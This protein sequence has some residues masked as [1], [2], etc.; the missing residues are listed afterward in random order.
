MTVSKSFPR[1]MRRA[2]FIG[3]RERAA[4]SFN[5]ANTTEF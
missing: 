3:I 4:F 2:R 1:S 5:F